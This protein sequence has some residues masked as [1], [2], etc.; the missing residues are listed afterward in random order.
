MK[1]TGKT[2]IFTILAHPATHVV[3]PA[4]YNHIFEKLRLD[5][6]YIPFDVQPHFIAGTLQAFRAWNNLGGFNVTTPNKESVAGFLDKTCPITS[7]I[8]A[9]N[10]VVRNEDGTFDGYNTDGVGAQKALG[11]VRSA[12]CL[13]IGA[14]GAAKSIVDALFTSRARRISII[15]RSEANAMVLLDIFQSGRVTLFDEA[16]LEDIDVVVQAT[17]IVDHVPFDLDL[18]RLK[19]NTRVL[20]TVM[21]P[22]VLSEKASEYGMEV[23]PGYAMLYY[24]T[25]HNFSLLT[26]IDIPDTV[27]KNSFHSVGY[28]KQLESILNVPDAKA[29]PRLP[30]KYVRHAD[31]IQNA[32]CTIHIAIRPCLRK[33]T[34]H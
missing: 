23:I 24:Q 17:P 27:L 7:R 18:K 12:H 22:T 25:K 19:K 9:V 31:L 5:M 6:A 2:R 1:I 8:N 29:T 3:A 20:E 34:N 16:D 13:V 10:T 11:V 33:R 14:G 32:V 21:R 15:N 4:I 28:S 26:G 30:L